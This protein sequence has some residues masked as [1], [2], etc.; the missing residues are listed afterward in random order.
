MKN[1]AQFVAF[2]TKLVHV[3]IIAIDGKPLSAAQLSDV[4]AA[5]ELRG[6]GVSDLVR[7]DLI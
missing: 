5:V 1:R 7:T 6:C 4:A 3:S 2:V